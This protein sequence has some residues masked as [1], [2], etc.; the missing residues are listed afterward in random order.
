MRTL[1]TKEVWGQIQIAL[2]KAGIGYTVSFDNHHGSIEKIIEIEPFGIY[3]FVS[4]EEEN[5]FSEKASDY[6]KDKF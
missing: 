3:N 1:I 2:A 5:A 6:Q 4:N